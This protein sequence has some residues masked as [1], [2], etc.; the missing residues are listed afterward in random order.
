MPI[1]L[2]PATEILPR[3]SIMLISYALFI[4]ALTSSVVAPPPSPR[5]SGAPPPLVYKSEF[6]PLM[7]ATDER[8]IGRVKYFYKVK[9]L[10]TRDDLPSW[11]RDSDLDTNLKFRAVDGGVGQVTIRRLRRQLSKISDHQYEF[12]YEKN[13][14]RILKDSISLRDAPNSGE[15]SLEGLWALVEVS[16]GFRKS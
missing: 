5:L 3:I 11:P 16:D 14:Y 6:K 9:T 7:G 2:W 15:T 10:A 13:G 8:L 1:I 4:F 12:R